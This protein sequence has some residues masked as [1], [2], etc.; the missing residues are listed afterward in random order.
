MDEKRINLENLKTK[1]LG[2]KIEIF[3]EID[4]TQLEILRRIEKK[5][6]EDGEIIVADIQTNGIRY[7]WKEMVYRRSKQYSFFVFYKNGL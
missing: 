4:S 2:R 7:T 6:I 1:K 5:E 3:K